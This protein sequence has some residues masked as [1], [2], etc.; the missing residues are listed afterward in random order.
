MI[1]K[2]AAYDFKTRKLETR[3]RLGNVL[4]TEWEVR[5]RTSSNRRYQRAA[6]F[7]TEDQALAYIAS[8]S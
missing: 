7:D 3:D 5:C 4:W 8:R 6:G 2:Q 1:V